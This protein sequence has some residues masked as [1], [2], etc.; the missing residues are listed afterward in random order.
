MFHLLLVVL[1]FFF[2]VDFYI[3]FYNFKKPIINFISPKILI[4]SFAKEG[5]IVLIPST[6]GKK[7]CFFITQISDRGDMKFTTQMIH[8]QFVWNLVTSTW[9]DSNMSSIG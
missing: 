3:T 4:L 9:I 8:T 6:N 2:K 7:L 1:L 5:K